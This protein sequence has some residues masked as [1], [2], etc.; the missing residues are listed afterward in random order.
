MCL[1]W[2]EAGMLQAET[3]FRRLIGHGELARLAL[4]VERDVA[5]TGMRGA[6][7]RRRR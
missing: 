1:S 6:A 3:E 4:A 5:A 7:G 2:T